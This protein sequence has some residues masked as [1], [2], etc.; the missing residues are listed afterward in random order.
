MTGIPGTR[1]TYFD[2]LDLSTYE[3]ALMRRGDQ[4][5]TPNVEQLSRLNINN[6]GR[7]GPRRHQELA[8]RSKL[9]MFLQEIKKA[10]TANTLIQ[11]LNAERSPS[12]AVGQ[13]MEEKR[14]AN[15]RI[16][17]RKLTEAR[18]SANAYG[19]SM[20]ELGQDPSN[21]AV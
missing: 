6:P 20:K 12:S 7:L 15:L 11:T 5:Y 16:Q 9:A 4:F 1:L 17:N 10:E 14:K 13:V 3:H 19:A 18:D 2:S 21:P 8:F